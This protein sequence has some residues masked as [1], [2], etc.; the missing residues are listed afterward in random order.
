MKVGVEVGKVDRHL[1]ECI[2]P[3]A[4]LFQ[5]ARAMEDSLCVRGP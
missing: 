3:S 2:E 5:L 1:D 4:D